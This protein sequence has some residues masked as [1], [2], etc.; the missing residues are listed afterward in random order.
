M[1]VAAVIFG[2][3][4][5]ALI[6][7][8]IR[9]LLLS[10]T[11]QAS[12]AE[13]V[14]YF[15]DNPVNF[16]QVRQ[17]Y[18]PLRRL[19]ENHSVALLVRKPITAQILAEDCPLPVQLA[20]NMSDLENF[21]AEHPVKVVFYVNNNKENFLPLRFP[22]QTHV[23]LSHGESDKAS[24]ASNQ[25]KA[26][27][28]AFIA[29]PA[30]R[31]RILRELRNFDP[32]HLVEI[33][34]PQLDTPQEKISIADDG[35]IVVLYAPTWEGDRPA[36]AYGSSVSHGLKI[37]SQLLS[38]PSIRV[39]YRPHPRS[40]VRERKHA[41]ASREI[42]SSIERANLADPSARHIIDTSKEFGW[43]FGAADICICDIS[44]V[45]A[46]WLTTRKPLVVTQPADPCAKID[47]A[48]LAGSL[49]LLPASAA[50]TVSDVVNRLVL[51]GTT[52]A[53]LSLVQHHF[54]DTTPG[55]SMA[56]FLKAARD[57]L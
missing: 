37:V 6:A 21:M 34:R 28:K 56:R 2:E 11:P 8:K 53:Q 45:A 15:A 35:R 46:D 52:E 12:E 27:D 41:V 50:S 51:E 26:Y 24:M 16:Y 42:K 39:I 55:A 3:L 48:G 1:H 23:H 5:N 31:E 32:S 36:M 49:E 7:P 13:F 38:D 9:S 17:W 22:K 29:G 20:R 47:P 57:L 19:S 54:G 43:L 14:L 30:S 18:E 33:G 40:G 44:A 4:R 10:R 25:L